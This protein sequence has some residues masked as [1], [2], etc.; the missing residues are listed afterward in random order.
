M[1]TIKYEKEFSGK[2]VIKF[3]TNS[4]EDQGFNHL[5]FSN[6][7]STDTKDQDF[8]PGYVQK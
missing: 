5:F 2:K 8:K 6:L 4:N 7:N 3:T 1:N